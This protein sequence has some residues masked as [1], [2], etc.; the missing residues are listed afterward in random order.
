MNMNNEK[1]WLTGLAAGLLL[2]AA[3]RA[4]AAGSDSLTVTI[5]PNAGYSVTVTTTGVGLD[6]GAVSLGASTQTV[7]PSTITV[8]S[9]YATTGLKLT[10]SMSGTGTPWTYAAN[11]AAQGTDQLAAWAVFTDTSVADYTVLGTTGTNSNYFTGTLATTAGSG[12]ISTSA[13]QVGTGAGPAQFIAAAGQ[14]GRKTMAA[15]PSNAAD[16]A[17]SR[18]HMWMYFVLPPSTTDNNPKRMTFTL[19]AGAPN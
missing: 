3:G 8:T 2:L 7:R 18:A 4:I 14:V 17:G 1:R 9:S 16:L 10:G 5:T 12:V 15:L 13:D 11:T 6:M 19:T